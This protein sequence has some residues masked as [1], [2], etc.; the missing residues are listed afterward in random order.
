MSYRYT[1]IL[2]ILHYFLFGVHSCYSCSCVLS[3][4]KILLPIDSKHIAVVSCIQKA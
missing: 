2:L 4:E 3:V 1:L